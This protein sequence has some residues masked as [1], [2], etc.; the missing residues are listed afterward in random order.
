MSENS[1]KPNTLKR[2]GA[3]LAAAAAMLG[4]I[5]CSAFETIGCPLDVDVASVEEAQ[6]A[7]L[8]P[9]SRVAWNWG[10]DSKEAKTREERLRIFTSQTSAATC[11][12]EEGFE[13]IDANVLRQFGI[14][15]SDS[16]E[17]TVV[18]EN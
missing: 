9:N 16:T 3:T 18:A 14:V 1:S 11:L 15:F 4:P 6:A 8:N 10:Q 2:V 7:Y 13:V 12:N 17:T 5:G